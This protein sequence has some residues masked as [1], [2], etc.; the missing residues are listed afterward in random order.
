MYSKK[1]N[2]YLLRSLGL[3][4]LIQL[5]DGFH[6]TLSFQ[7]ECSSLGVAIRLDLAYFILFA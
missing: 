7:C 3:A 1:Y 6:R 5:L 4:R 2:A